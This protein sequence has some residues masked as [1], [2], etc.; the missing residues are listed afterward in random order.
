M[1]TNK[2][3]FFKYCLPG[4]LLLMAFTNSAHAQTVTVS[5]LVTESTGDPVPGVNV[6]VKGATLAGTITNAQGNYTLEGVPADATLIYSFIGFKTQE[7]AVEGR[8][9]ISLV[10]EEEIT[11]LAE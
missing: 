4:L 8:T 6:V 5:G 3:Y 10:L 1:Q 11:T 9:H 2:Y 7:V